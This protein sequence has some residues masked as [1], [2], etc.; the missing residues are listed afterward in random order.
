MQEEKSFGTRI[1]VTLFLSGFI[2]LWAI[3]AGFTLTSAL[4]HFIMTRKKRSEY[5]LGLRVAEIA[6]FA[7]RNVGAIQDE[8]LFVKLHQDV[9]HLTVSGVAENCG[10]WRVE[11][12]LGA[13]VD[14]DYN[15]DNYAT[16]EAVL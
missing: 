15:C 11:K 1:N 9:P 3:I 4:S 6:R 10:T 16:A 5:A 14:I 8:S 12:V 13:M 7:R 2:I